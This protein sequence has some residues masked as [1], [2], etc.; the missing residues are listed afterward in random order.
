MTAE[1]SI[2]AQ[3]AAALLAI[4]EAIETA[5]RALA[6]AVRTGEGQEGVQAGAEE[7]YSAPAGPGTSEL[8]VAALRLDLANANAAIGRVRALADEYA[9]GRGGPTAKR[10]RAALD[11]QEAP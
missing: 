2:S 9:Q 10:I 5:G 3:H 1:P 4:A 8:V 6:D 7:P 11:G